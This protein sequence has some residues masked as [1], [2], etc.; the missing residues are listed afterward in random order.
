MKYT[1]LTHVFVF[2]FFLCST[3]CNL[4]QETH[5]KRTTYDQ[6][7]FFSTMITEVE[8]QWSADSRRKKEVKCAD[9]KACWKRVSVYGCCLL[10]VNRQAYIH[11]IVLSV[12]A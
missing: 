3:A 1:W 7:F 5:A 10:C 6:V 8:R 2:C 11:V 4:V 12:S 9:L